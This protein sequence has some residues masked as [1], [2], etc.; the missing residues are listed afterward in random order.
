MLLCIV[1]LGIHRDRRVGKGG[2][3]A[4]RGDGQYVGPY[5]INFVQ[6]WVDQI[7]GSIGTPAHHFTGKVAVLGSSC[8]FHICQ[9]IGEAADKCFAT[10]SSFDDLV[11]WFKNQFGYGVNQVYVRGLRE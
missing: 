4:S 1:D 5:S 6:E 8:E 9:H 10:V 7:W 11:R 3:V 2:R